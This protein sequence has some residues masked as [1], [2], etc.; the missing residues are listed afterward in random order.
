MLIFIPPLHHKLLIPLFVVNQSSW[1]TA[2]M[3]YVVASPTYNFLYE[4]TPSQY[5]LCPVEGFAACTFQEENSLVYNFSQ[6]D[7]KEKL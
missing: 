2:D 7:F 4:N 1:L 6:N 5:A 3:N